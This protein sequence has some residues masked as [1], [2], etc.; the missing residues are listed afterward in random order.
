MQKW[1]EI[2]SKDLICFVFLTLIELIIDIDGISERS[3]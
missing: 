3:Y 1:N 2:H